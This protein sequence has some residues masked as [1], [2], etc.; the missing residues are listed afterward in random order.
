MSCRT[1][2]STFS[3]SSLAIPQMDDEVQVF[4]HSIAH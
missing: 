3:H 2:F 1:A 4:F